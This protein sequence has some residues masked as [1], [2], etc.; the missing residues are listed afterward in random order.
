MSHEVDLY[1]YHA[2]LLYSLVSIKIMSTNNC[3]FIEI[4]RTL[5]RRKTEKCELFV[6][7][8]L[9]PSKY[10]PMT[11]TLPGM[12]AWW[13]VFTAWQTDSSDLVVSFVE[14]LL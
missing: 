9:I 5:L 7:I 12:Q 13:D 6:F 1:H 10:M 4:L 8:I 14:T 2:S 3:S 11:V